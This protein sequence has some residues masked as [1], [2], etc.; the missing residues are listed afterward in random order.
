MS[1]FVPACMHTSMFVTPCVPLVQRS[2]SLVCAT[3]SRDIFVQD[4]V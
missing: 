4:L 1:W 3:V 2:H